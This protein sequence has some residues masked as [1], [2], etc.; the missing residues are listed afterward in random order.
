MESSFFMSG[1][2]SI[3]ALLK[4]I[5]RIPVALSIGVKVRS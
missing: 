3:L 4:N 2:Y 5:L 1:G